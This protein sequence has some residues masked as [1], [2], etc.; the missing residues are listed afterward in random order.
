MAW[1]YLFGTSNSQFIYI[2]KS[3]DDAK[4]NLK[5]TQDQIDLLPVYMRCES[6]MD[7]DGKRVKAKKNATE[8]RNPIN[9][10]D[11][12]VKPKATS[13]EAALS[14]ARGLTSAL[15][16][17]DE[18]E[19][20]NYIKTIIVNSVSTYQTAAE[21]A[22]RNHALYG[23]VLTCTPGDLDTKQGLEAQELLANTAEWTERLYDMNEEQIGKWMDA[24]GEDFNRI[25][26]IE[27]SYKQIGKTEEWLRDI[28]AKIGDKLTVRRE[29]LL[30]RLHGSSLSPFDQEDIEYIVSTKQVPIDELWLLEYYKI[31]I[32][33]RLE[34]H[35]PYI[36]GVD[37]STGTGDD[38][39]AI[40][41]LNPYTVCPDAEF[42]CS[43]IGETAYENLIKEI[44][45]VLPKAVLVI[46][47]N[48][49]GDGIIDHL[50]HSP[51]SNRLYFDKARDLVD[52]NMRA[53][54][55]VESMLKKQ[56]SKKKYYGVYTGTQ[57]RDDM[58][59][60]LAR[61]VSEYKE[62][63][64]TKNIIGDL[65]GLVRTSSGKVEAGPGFHD[66]SIM[67]YLIALYVYYHGNNLLMFGINKAALEEELNNA[68]LKRPEEIDPTLVDPSL[69]KGAKE[70][71]EKEKKYMQEFNYADMMKE[72]Q[73]KAQVESYRLQKAGL[74][75]TDTFKNTEEVVI[76]DGYD[77]G[78]IPMDFFSSI[79]GF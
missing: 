42:K 7:D 61:H 66:D 78:E 51:I 55:T 53:N 46:E 57:S 19:F 11:I 22:K 21:N 73:R 59:A 32:Y 2:N 67:S 1:G 10:N 49:M 47:R 20:T 69:I 65:S 74:V 8:L 29:I 15:H 33:R 40:T 64:I 50:L 56:A 70:Q 72:I 34:K 35:I 13:Y 23:R 75:D 14:I 28:S 48:S 44:M 77:D 68:G 54:E 30:Q 60:I 4:L 71:E 9:K 45:K 58:M 17:Y 76:D 39:N 26:Y 18:P 6:I 31:D 36:I 16:F 25:V 52:E 38:N 62:K 63:F 37:C 43:Y 5:R 27:Y 12:I 24:Q 41:I 3:G 79:N